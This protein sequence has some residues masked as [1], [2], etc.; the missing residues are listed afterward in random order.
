MAAKK[1]KKKDVVAIDHSKIKYDPFRRAFYHPTP[2]IAEMTEEDAENLRLALDGI[3]IK[4]IDCPKPV[5]KW[6]HCGLPASWCA[7]KSHIRIV[8]LHGPEQ[9]RSYQTTGVRCANFYP[10][11]SHPCH[12][13]WPGCGWHRQDRFRQDSR[14]PPSYVPTNQRPA[15]SRDDGRP[16]W[17]YHDADA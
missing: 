11:S 7:I 16:D 14:F 2:E 5:M 1:A 10:V 9:P 17:N 4:G 13:V 3:K 8:G 15:T 12:H 6:S